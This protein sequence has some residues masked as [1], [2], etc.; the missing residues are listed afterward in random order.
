MQLCLFP[1]CAASPTFPEFAGNPYQNADF[2]IQLSKLI[3]K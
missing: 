3:M 1:L 2:V